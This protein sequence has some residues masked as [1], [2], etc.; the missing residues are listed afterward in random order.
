VNTTADLVTGARRKLLDL[1]N[2]ESGLLQDFEVSADG[3]RFLLIRAEPGSRP[4]QLNVI[5]NW[6]DELRRAVR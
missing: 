5:T 1:S 4:V 6:F 3:Q 2:Y